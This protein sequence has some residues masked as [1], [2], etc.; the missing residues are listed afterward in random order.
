MSGCV[1][2]HGDEVKMTVLKREDTDFDIPSGNNTGAKPRNKTNYNGH[3][4]K[5]KARRATMNSMACANKVHT[6]AESVSVT[7]ISETNGGA[8]IAETDTVTAT[9]NGVTETKSVTVWNGA[10]DPYLAKDHFVAEAMAAFN[11]NKRQPW[12]VILESNEDDSPALPFP[13][14][15]LSN[16]ARSQQYLQTFSVPLQSFDQFLIDYGKVS[17]DAI[18]A[19]RNG[20]HGAT[21]P[22]DLTLDIQLDNKVLAQDDGVLTVPISIWLDSYVVSKFPL[23]F[24]ISFCSKQGNYERVWNNS[25]NYLSSSTVTDVGQPLLGT[26]QS[27]TRM[28]LYDHDHGHIT[29]SFFDRWV[30]VDTDVLRQRAQKPLTGDETMQQIV[31]YPVDRTAKYLDPLMYLAVTRSREMFDAAAEETGIDAEEAPIITNGSGSFLRVPTA[32]LLQTIDEVASQVDR[33]RH[34]MHPNQTFMRIFIPNFRTGFT[35]LQK[36]YMPAFAHER[37]PPITLT[38]VF[39]VDQLVV[40][41]ISQQMIEAATAGERTSD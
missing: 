38:F 15:P 16:S 17:P 41:P 37:N 7:R 32:Q 1:A 13:Y 30:N 28:P 31:Q 19:A 40:N 11:Q 34:T 12:D 10:D 22:A 9:S 14:L 18:A 4:S 36:I 5:K 26:C 23:P 3:K 25:S 39:G 35:N 8:A 24:F 33:P 6:A 21:L 2:R 27:Y 20:T 29:S